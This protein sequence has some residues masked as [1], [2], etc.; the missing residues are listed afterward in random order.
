MCI[1]QTTGK[2][3]A[4]LLERSESSLGVYEL[5]DKMLTRAPSRPLSHM[6]QVVSHT[7][8]M[9]VPNP[10][11]ATIPTQWC[12]CPQTSARLQGTGASS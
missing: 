12:R 7:R 9:T 3:L 11:P 2:K 10:P 5:T 4:F 8:E 1:A 6:R